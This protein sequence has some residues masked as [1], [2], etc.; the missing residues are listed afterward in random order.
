M[1]GFWSGLLDIP[2]LS[3]AE[4]RQDRGFVGNKAIVQM[5]DGLNLIRH[6]FNSTQYREM[7]PLAEPGLHH[8]IAPVGFHELTIT[9]PRHWRAV[10]LCRC[11]ELGSWLVLV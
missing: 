10:L 2:P 7:T 8:L 9:L 6:C 3:F 4:W 5:Q 11:G 1:T